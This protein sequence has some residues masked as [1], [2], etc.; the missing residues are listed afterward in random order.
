MND[1]LLLMNVVG[2]ERAAQ[3]AQMTSFK[4]PLKVADIVQVKLEIYLRISIL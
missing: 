2:R 4:S 3:L 1:F